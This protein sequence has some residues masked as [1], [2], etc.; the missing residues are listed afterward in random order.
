MELFLSQN[1]IVAL[2]HYLAQKIDNTLPT[3][4]DY[5]EPITLAAV[6]KGGIPFANLLA[7]LLVLDV[8]RVSIHKTPEGDFSSLPEGQVIF[9]D[10]IVDTG[11][12]MQKILDSLAHAQKFISVCLLL[13]HT[14]RLYPT[15][16]GYITSSKSFFVGFGLDDREGENR[17]LNDIYTDGEI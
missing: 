14:A 7:S 17:K 5:R 4:F 1:R 9:A 10:C 11:A 15:Y 6:A 8:K 2:T 12:T 16:Y 13:R 3:I